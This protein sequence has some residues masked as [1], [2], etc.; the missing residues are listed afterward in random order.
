[1]F[2]QVGKTKNSFKHGHKFNIFLFDLDEDTSDDELNDKFID[3]D[4]NNNE[5]NVNGGNNSEKSPQK[6]SN[7]NKNS[8]ADYFISSTTNFN[9]QQQTVFQLNPQSPKN[10]S[11]STT[12]NNFHVNQYYYHVQ[13]LQQQ[14]L[15]NDQQQKQ[16]KG[17]QIEQILEKD[18]N[19]SN[20]VP[21]QKADRVVTVKSKAITNGKNIQKMEQQKNELKSKTKSDSS[22]KSN[23]SSSSAENDKEQLKSPHIN[24]QLSSLKLNH[25]TSSENGLHFF[26]NKYLDSGFNSYFKLDLHDIRQPT[27]VSAKIQQLLNTLKVKQQIKLI[28]NKRINKLINIYYYLKR[29]KRRPLNEYFEDNQEEVAS[30]YLFKQ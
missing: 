7:Q 28:Q 23:R 29:P 22:K 2:I 14:E 10:G 21:H 26:L 15:Q 3:N 8:F 16:Q 5:K 24:Q 18:L 9:N 13:Q 19:R 1:M 4:A 27:R 25:S 6:S 30:K 12:N 17:E 20:Y 11:E